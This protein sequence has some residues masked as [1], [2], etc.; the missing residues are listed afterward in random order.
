MVRVKMPDPVGVQV[1]FLVNLH[2]YSS[3]WSFLNH[4]Q[5]FCVECG[6]NGWVAQARKDA[7]TPHYFPTMENNRSLGP[8]AREAL[9]HAV[10]QSRYHRIVVSPSR[11]DAS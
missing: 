10:E 2:C 11:Q 5:K 9:L 1:L 8:V 3:I 4:F 6:C 7:L